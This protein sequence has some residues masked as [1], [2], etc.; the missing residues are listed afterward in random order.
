MTPA[1]EAKAGRPWGRP[2]SMASTS[3]LVPTLSS[4]AGGEAEASAGPWLGSAAGASAR[5]RPDD[6]L[7]QAASM[8]S[9]SIA[10]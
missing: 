1:P 2:G 8:R 6:E 5:P 3:A 4:S 10:S 9:I 7:K